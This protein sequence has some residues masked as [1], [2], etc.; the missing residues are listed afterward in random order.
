M[1]RTGHILIFRIGEGWVRTLKA[2]KSE[3]TVSNTAKFVASNNRDK[4]VF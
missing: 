1:P 2:G 3:V 4:F